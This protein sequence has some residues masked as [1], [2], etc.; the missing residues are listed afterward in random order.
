MQDLGYEEKER[1]V[2]PRVQKTTNYQLAYQKCQKL[3]NQ[4]KQID[5]AKILF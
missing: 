3:I 1:D 4:F 2:K 5:G